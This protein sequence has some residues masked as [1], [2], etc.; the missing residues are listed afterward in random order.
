MSGNRM[1]MSGFKEESGNQEVRVDVV[2]SDPYSK[3][4]S[5]LMVE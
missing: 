1:R 2:R 3:T 4:H 5:N